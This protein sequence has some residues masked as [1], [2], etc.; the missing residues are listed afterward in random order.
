MKKLNALDY[1]KQP[2]PKS[3]AND[4]G[5]DIVYPIIKDSGLEIKDAVRTYTEHI[6]LQISNAIS[7]LVNLKPQTSNLKLLEQVAG[8][9]I[10]F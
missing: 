6:V 5:T 10:H 1:Y 3:L 2:Y 9:S 4:F 8:P 7:T